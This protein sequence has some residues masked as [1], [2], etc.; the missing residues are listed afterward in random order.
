LPQEKRQD[1]SMEYWPIVG[2]IKST[3][4]RC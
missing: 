3:I 1:K 2:R 4:S